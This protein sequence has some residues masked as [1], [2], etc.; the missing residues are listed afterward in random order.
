MLKEDWGGGGLVVVFKLN[1]VV[2]PILAE[3]LIDHACLHRLLPMI[4][5]KLKIAVPLGMLLKKPCKVDKEHVWRQTG[6]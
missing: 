1:W 6:H 3:D 2:K 4:N 5:V